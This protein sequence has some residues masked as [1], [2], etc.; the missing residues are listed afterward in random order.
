MQK[1]TLLIILLGIFVVVISSIVG[2]TSFQN[3]KPVSTPQTPKDR[4][5]EVPV[6]QTPQETL[7]QMLRK[8]VKREFLPS[9]FEVTDHSEL[10]PLEP[11]EDD[12]N[13][14]FVEWDTEGA[15]FSALVAYNKTIPKDLGE[16]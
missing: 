9:T 5:E 2:L 6:S 4:L 14:Y 16:R 12:A 11:S 7:K 1:K 13:Y 15:R 10:I 8:T 3:K